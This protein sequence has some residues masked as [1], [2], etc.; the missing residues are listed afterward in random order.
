MV[1]VP[2]ISNGLC[3]MWHKD[4]GIG[5]T[6]FPEMICAGYRGGGKDSCQV[7][8]CRRCLGSGFR[9]EINETASSDSSHTHVSRT[10]G[11]EARSYLRL[12]FLVYR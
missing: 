1:D 11:C 5:V 2:I 6:I 4:K 3:E 9:F 7:S 10:S 12:I 8:W